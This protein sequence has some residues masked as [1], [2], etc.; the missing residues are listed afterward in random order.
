[1]FGPGFDSL[2][3]HLNNVVFVRFFKDEEIGMENRMIADVL[4]QW[5]KDNC[6][7]LP[8]RKTKDPYLIWIS[9][10]ILQQTR[11]A[12]GLGYFNR[13]VERFPDVNMLAVAD[14][15]E[16]L[17]YWQGLGYYSRARNLHAAAKDVV[18]RFGGVF[19]RTKEEVLSLKGIG[20]YTAAA[21][22]SF[23]YGLPYA[24]VDGNVYR[25]LARL[26]D[27][28]IPIDSGEGKKYFQ[29]LA[30]S[31]LPASQ[32]DLF[33]QAMMEFGA[34]QCVPRGACCEVC[35]LND[36]CM[37]RAAGRVE[38]LPVKMGKTLARPRYF[39]YV[40]LHDEAGRLLLQRRE[41]M[42]IWRNLYEFPL[43][44]TD[45]PI[46]YKELEQTSFFQHLLKGVR[47]VEV[48][49]EFRPKK[50]V[51]SHQVIYAVFYEI[52]VSDFAVGI[53]SYIKIEI[54]KF[55]C[56]PVSRLMQIY[57]EEMQKN[58]LLKEC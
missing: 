51:L 16:V 4:I 31:L 27:L 11:V 10:V 43:M 2:L 39:N 58:S 38:D 35:L 5:Y 36:K 23:A 26:F 46:E 20:E 56:Y 50:H 37:A 12:Q 22:C 54:S 18:E 55:E 45:R 40:H 8:W 25:V 14:E 21:I 49:R 13:F 47:K 30:Q 3:L 57:W 28:D 44:E 1:V 32:V 29:D 24:T 7:D 33:N 15:S 48:V 6:R 52:K 17:L 9:E 34:L 19:P 53:Q 42:D 41:K